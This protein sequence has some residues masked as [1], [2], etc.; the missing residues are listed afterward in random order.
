MSCASLFRRVKRFEGSGQMF[1]RVICT[2]VVAGAFQTSLK[3]REAVV[4]KRTTAPSRRRIYCSCGKPVPSAGKRKPSEACCGELLGSSQIVHDET[5][6]SGG[7]AATKPGDVK[8][9]GIGG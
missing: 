4:R 6:L 2:N 7:S 8:P 9:P 5:H 3:S 1:E